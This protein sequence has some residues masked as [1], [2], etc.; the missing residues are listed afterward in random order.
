MKPLTS[1]ALS[2]FRSFNPF[3]NIIHYYVDL[4]CF[5][6]SPTPPRDWWALN[7]RK[8]L[9]NLFSLE[10][11]YRSTAVRDLFLQQC[12][13]EMESTKKTVC[14]ERLGFKDFFVPIVKNGKFLGSLQAGAFRQSEVTSEVLENNW[15][16]LSGLEPA[17]IL[18][19]YR[20]FVR[21]LLDIPVLEGPLFGGFRESLEIFAELLSDRANPND[22]A[23]KRLWW[24]LRNVFS[25]GL[26]HS[27]WLDW[28]LGRP[29]SESLP[30]WTK[31]MEEWAWIKDEIGIARIPTT[32]IT[33]IP[34]RPGAAHLDWTAEMVRVYRFQRKSFLFGQ[35]LP[36]TVGGK[37]DDYGAVFVTSAD[38]RIPR[39]AQRRKI[40]AL[41]GRIHDFARK[42]LG[43]PVLVG[44]G[45]TVAPGDPLD[46]SYRQA[47]MALHL[48]HDPERS[49]LYFNEK[50]KEM[51]QGS[52]GGLR[53]MLDRL[54]RSFRTASFPGL[55]ALQEEFVKQAIH[56]SFN[57]PQ[58]I[59]WHFQYALDRLAETAGNRMDLRKKE[60]G[61]LRMEISA[62]ME[63]AATLQEL[64]LEFKEALR[65]L[66][67]RIERP[68]LF[69]ET[70]SVK[71]ITDHLN[72]NFRKPLHIKTLARRAGMSAST[73]SRRF[74]K[75]TGMGLEV[76]LQNRRLAEAKRLLGTTSL[77]VAVIA[78]DC[79]FG[80]ASPFARFFRKKTG[81]TPQKFR[82]K[83]LA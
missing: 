14:G 17:A 4:S 32:V 78:R 23:G 62:K 13:K 33:V 25:K 16:E 52:F 82:K 22:A 74:Q 30:A 42:E 60:A 69:E 37:L 6:L 15:R 57:N 58:E 28:A 29:T 50:K 35:T 21:V 44:V 83:S 63:Q 76:Y 49:V 61:Q 41:A 45:E 47:V 31:R 59:R 38:P 71:K 24:L 27:Y 80:S 7:R 64:V 56:L 51:T 68:R 8:R 3:H 70:F 39:L 19:E 20:E 72:Q 26:P 10:I 54:D 18:P 55:E 40:E 2:F 75:S 66:A 53:D 9:T 36:E 11:K 77:S 1:R 65:L 79:G 48:R 67:Q 43:V 73:L 81:I 12:F 46:D 5:L 34:Q